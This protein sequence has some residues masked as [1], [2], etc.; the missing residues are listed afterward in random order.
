MSFGRKYGFIGVIALLLSQVACSFSTSNME[1]PSEL[2]NLD[3][4]V[5]ISETWRRFFSVDVD[6]STSIQP[7]ITD[8]AVFTVDA[9]GDLAAYERSRGDRIWAR[10]IG[11]GITA[12]LGLGESLMFAVTSDGEVIALSRQDGSIVWKQAVNSEVLAAPVVESGQVIV[13]TVD[14]KLIALSEKTGARNWIYQR[15]EPALS[16]R[17]TST[18]IVFQGVVV[19]GFG[20]GML[21]AVK[22][23]SGRLLWERPVSY[24]KGR[25]QVQR[26]AD[27]DAPPLVAGIRMFAV[28]YQGKLVAL[29]MRN[30]RESWSKSVS[31]V[32]A[33]SADKIN[34]YVSDE[35]GVVRA[36]D[37]ESGAVVWVQEKLRGR[38][39]TGPAV[40]GNYIVAGDYDGYTH[41]L[42]SRDGS[43]VARHRVGVSAI[44]N[45]PITSNDLLFVSNTDGDLAA[46]RWH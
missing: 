1:D 40:A 10:D 30:G 5:R 36:Y 18:P 31:S 38:R 13:Q 29:N 41:W 15:S 9:D 21:V 14:G 22:L 19:T 32:Q 12:G 2:V 39:L 16:V 42:D 11:M 23:D 3:A 8:S 27:V 17:G 7:A 24:P 35:H 28:N 4:S 44:V 33:M 20:G 26:L 6:R 34:V 43:L 25:N 45:Q 37:Q 46:I